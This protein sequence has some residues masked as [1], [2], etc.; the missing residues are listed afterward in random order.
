M[1]CRSSFALRTGVHQ[2]NLSLKHSLQGP[3]V[4]SLYQILEHFYNKTFINKI[5]IHLIGK[6]SVD[7][8]HA[9]DDTVIEWNNPKKSIEGPRP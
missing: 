9:I 1:H 2:A 7:D 8:I 3:Q 4:G 6:R 5:A